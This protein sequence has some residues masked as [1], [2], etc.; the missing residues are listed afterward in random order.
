MAMRTGFENKK[1][2]AIASGLG[3]VLVI[4][5]IWFYKQEFGS[6]PAPQST[7]AP[8]PAPVAAPIPLPPSAPPTSGGSAKKVG[9]I[10][11]DPTLHTEVLVQAESVSYTGKG[12]NIF[13]QSSAPAVVNI[14]KPKAPARPMTPIVAGPPQPPPPPP[15]NLKFFGYATPKSGTKRVFLLQ[16]EDIFLASEGEVVNHRYKVVRIMPFSVQVE[17]IP[18][19]NTQNL[20]LVQN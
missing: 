17:D 2:L 13:S 7:A 15:I 3:V 20:P 8:S 9:H 18:Y 5:L 12:R 10:N 6:S 14:P 4:A 19:H 11:L 16:G 1:Q